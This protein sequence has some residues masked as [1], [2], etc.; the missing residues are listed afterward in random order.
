MPMARGTWVMC[1]A[2]GFPP[3]C[4]FYMRMAGHYV[5]MVSGTDEHGTAIQVQ[6]DKEGL[7][8]P[9]RPP[10]STTG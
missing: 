3:T 6:A 1:Q 8:L 10:T 4:S 7:T 2:S 9:S 5:L